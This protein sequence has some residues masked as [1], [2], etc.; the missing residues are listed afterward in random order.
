MIM[1]FV[2]GNFGDALNIRENRYHLKDAVINAKLK[3]SHR[4]VL[5]IGNN[6]D[7]LHR[8]WRQIKE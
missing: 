2:L 1:L 5:H 8:M 3:A 4:N 6:A 7:P